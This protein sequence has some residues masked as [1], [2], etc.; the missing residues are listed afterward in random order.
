M[1]RKEVKPLSPEQLR[2][3]ENIE[4][5]I[6][7]FIADQRHDI[8]AIMTLMEITRKLEL[9]IQKRNPEYTGFLD[10]GNIT[11]SEE[12]ILQLTQLLIA[13]SAHQSLFKELVQWASVALQPTGRSGRAALEC[14]EMVDKTLWFIS[15]TSIKTTQF[16]EE[17][18]KQWLE[19]FKKIWS[20][21]KNQTRICR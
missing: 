11:L 16:T 12:Q 7:Q 4:Y 21:Y 5:R 3:R 8:D 15:E 14:C 19:K 17:Q 2:S 20:D 18:N 13:Q 9:L 10:S 6:I 1:A